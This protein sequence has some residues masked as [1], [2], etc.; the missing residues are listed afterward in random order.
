MNEFLNQALIGALLGAFVS[1]IATWMISVQRLPASFRVAILGFP[2]AGKTTLITGVFDYLFR[3]GLQGASVMPRGDETIRRVNTNLERLELG[4][5]IEPTTDQDLFAYR[6]EIQVRSSLFHKRYKLEIGDFPGE[7]SVAFAESSGDW[8]HEAPYFNWAVSADAF[9]FVVDIG[10]V[11]DDVRGIYVAQQKK[12][13]RAAWQRVQEFHLDGPGDIRRKSLTLVF[14]KADLLMRQEE[15]HDREWSRFGRHTFRLKPKETES[16]QSGTEDVVDQ[17]N[18]LVQ[19]FSRESH[20]LGVVFTSVLLEKDE[21]RLGIPKLVANI[22]PRRNF[23]PHSVTRAV[24]R[25]L[26]WQ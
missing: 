22:L 14:T 1:A 15:S 18:D 4:Q 25:S 11:L 12:A 24:K 17:F 19:Y 3:R 26:L 20:F 9:L 23:I 10:R 8:L 16:F 13:F 6:A 7:D 21:E 2:R 5:P